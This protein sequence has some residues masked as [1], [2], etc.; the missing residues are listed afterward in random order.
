MELNQLHYPFYKQATQINGF[1]LKEKKS[2]YY[3]AV[4]GRDQ[5]EHLASP[6]TKSESNYERVQDKSEMIETCLGPT[7]LVLGGVTAQSAVSLL[8]QRFPWVLHLKEQLRITDGSHLLKMPFCPCPLGYGCFLSS[9]SHDCCLQCMGVQHAEAAFVDGSC[10]HCKRMTMA[11][12]QSRHSLLMGLERALSVTTRAGF[13]DMSREPS[14]S[15]LGDL[16]V[17]FEV[18]MWNLC[19]KVKWKKIVS[20]HDQFYR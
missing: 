4:L 18:S 15:D 14:A 13:S 5:L 11:V 20:T 3:I 2:I 9:N 7:A 10:F 8:I 12:L 19:A 1:V 6:M 17:I 16:R